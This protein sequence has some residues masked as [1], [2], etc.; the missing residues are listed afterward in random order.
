MQPQSPNPNFDFM[1]KDNQPTKRG[2]PMPNL[3]KPAKVGLFV[4]GGLIL[5][6]ILS[7]LL[8]GHSRGKFQPIVNVLAR[9]QET[10]R[11][12]TLVQQQ[13]Q[14]QD[15]TSQALATTASSSLASEKTQLLAY[16]SNNHLKVS[17]AQLA[18]DT[19]K[20]TD[21]SLQSAAQN[22]GLDAA[23]ANYLKTALA[24]YQTDLQTAYKSAGPNGKAILSDAFEST[25]ALL[26]SPPLSS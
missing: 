9:D 7:S 26:K 12:T 19:D 25:V 11:V 13:L 8:S 20:S 21:A 15:P 16:L 10:L 23:Y 2:L 4:I 17:S 22:N 3:P 24:K 18:A 5:I 1:L 6:I 14:L